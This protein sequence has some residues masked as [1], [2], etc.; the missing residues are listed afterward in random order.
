MTPPPISPFARQLPSAIVA[1]VEPL[2]GELSA[3][4]LLGATSSIDHVC[5]RVADLARYEQLKTEIALVADLLSEAFVNGRPIASYRLRTPVVLSSGRSL[6]VLELPAPKPGASYAEGFEHIEVVTRAPLEEFISGFPALPFETR[7]LSAPVNR[8]I[9]LKLPSGLVKFHEQTLAAVILA[10]RETLAA[11]VQARVAVFDFDDTLVASKEPFLK[12]F[13]LALERHLGRSVP[14]AEVRAKQRPTYPEFFDNL[15][16][17]AAEIGQVLERF[18]SE[19][20]PVAQDCVLPTGIVSLLSCLVSEGVDV[21]VWTARDPWTTVSTLEG[22]GLAPF[23]TR[24]HGYDGTGPSKPHPTEALQAVC[25]PARCVVIGDSG[26][27]HQGA[28][29][30]GAAFLQAAWIQRHDLAVPS[31]RICSLPLAALSR[32]MELLSD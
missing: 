15:G 5:Y 25:R 24:V 27:D 32:T 22:I 9:S 6:D 19:W 23:V 7:N 29:N 14:F 4:G 28:A 26:S 8:D 16:I 21:H 20:P 17:P 2:L 18:R 31:E 12:A 11:R 1:F 13:H 30:L 3:R 10:E